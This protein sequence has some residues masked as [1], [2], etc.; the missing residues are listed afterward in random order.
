MHLIPHV[1]AAN[2]NPAL[3]LN[4]LNWEL[5]SGKKGL[6]GIFFIHAKEIL[7]AVADPAWYP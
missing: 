1:E 4:T 6:K 7:H 2:A 3:D 5:I